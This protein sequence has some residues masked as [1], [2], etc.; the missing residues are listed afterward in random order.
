MP[1]LDGSL[2]RFE[3]SVAT[4][5]DALDKETAAHFAGRLALYRPLVATIKRFSS[6]SLNTEQDRGRSLSSKGGVAG[7]VLDQGPIA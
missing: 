7:A 4:D 5:T 3:S 2:L 6:E 1:D